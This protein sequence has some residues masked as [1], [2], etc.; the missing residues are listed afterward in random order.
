MPDSLPP[1]SFALNSSA[2]HVVAAREDMERMHAK[3]KDMEDLLRDLSYAYWGDAK[4]R[5]NGTRH[6]TKLIG[7]RL[8]HLISRMDQSDAAH[9][10]Y[11]DKT[12]AETCIGKAELAKHLAEHETMSAHD[13]ALEIARINAATEKS[14]S[15][16][17]E[18][19]AIVVAGVMLV[20]Q[21]TQTIATTQLE[22]EIHTRTEATR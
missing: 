3:V 8:R 22:R 7:I 21:I 15:K 14:K 11:L 1:G 19:T 5:N 18:I 10:H 9:R 17:K 6:R 4:L 13:L 2:T 16:W 20:G 12:R